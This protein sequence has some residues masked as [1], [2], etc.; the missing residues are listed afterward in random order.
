M[1]PIYSHSFSLHPSLQ[2]NLLFPLYPIHSLIFGTHALPTIHTLLYPMLTPSIIIYQLSLFP[3]SNFSAPLSAISR[4]LFSLP[5]A[6]LTLSIVIDYTLPPVLHIS[7]LSAL[8][9]RI[10][11]SL[12]SSASFTLTNV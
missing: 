2:S 6:L 9:Y 11:M 1:S 4:S 7:S 8:R 3:S 10:I 5:F 12:L